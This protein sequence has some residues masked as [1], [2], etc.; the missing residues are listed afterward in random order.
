[1]RRHGFGL[2]ALFPPRSLTARV[3]LLTSLWAVVAL[4]VVGALISTL[5]ERTARQGFENLLGAQLYNLVNA[6]SVDDGGALQGNPDLGDL[7]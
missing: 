6:V 3:I 7:R 4:F 1:M 5:Y 2:R